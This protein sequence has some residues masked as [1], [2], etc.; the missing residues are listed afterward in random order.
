MKPPTSDENFSLMHSV[1]MM[2]IDS[3]V[4]FILAWYLDNVH[5]G[6]YGVPRPLYFPLQVSVFADVVILCMHTLFHCDAEIIY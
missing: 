1:I 2:V 4:L 5:P 3:I 6:D